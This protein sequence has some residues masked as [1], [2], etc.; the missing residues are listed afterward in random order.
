MLSL[1][2]ALNTLGFQDVGEH[3]PKMKV[4]QKQFYHLSFIHHPDRPGGHNP[5]YQKITEAYKFIGDYIEKHYEPRD[6]TEEE[7]ARRAYKSFNFNDIKENFSS[8]TIKIDNNLSLIWDTILTKH[9]GEPKDRSG[10]GNGKH[11]KHCDYT[12]DN[13]NH[14]DITIGK[15][16]IPKKD[17]QS[18][19]TIQSNVVGNFL[20]AHFVSEHLP[21]LLAE[22][23]ASVPQSA[24]VQS[25]KVAAQQYHTNGKLSETKSK[26][27]LKKK[28]SPGALGLCP[29]P[30]FDIPSPFNVLPATPLLQEDATFKCFLCPNYYS[31]GE[32]DA[33]EKEA[34]NMKCNSCDYTSITKEDMKEH[35]KNTHAPVPNLECDQCPFITTLNRSLKTHIQRKHPDHTTQC[36]VPDLN[37]DQCHFNTTTN[38]SLKTHIQKKHPDQGTHCFNSYSCP[39][40]NYQ[41]SNVISMNQHIKSSHIQKLDVHLS[42]LQQFHCQDCPFTATNVETLSAHVKK[43]H[44]L[45][46]KSKTF[47]CEFCPFSDTHQINLKKHV[48]SKHAKLKCHLCQFT[49]SSEFS[50]TLHKEHNHT[51]IP[52]QMIYP[53]TLCG[54]TFAL[55]GDLESHIH[56]RHTT[57]HDTTAPPPDSSQNHSIALLLEEQIDMATTLK[58]FRESINAQLSAIRDDHEE[59]REDIKKHIEENAAAQSTSLTQF[60]NL[61]S[62]I[63]HQTR[64]I[65]QFITCFASKPVA[66][67]SESGTSSA[68]S[69]SSVPL[70]ATSSPLPPRFPTTSLETPASMENARKTNTAVPPRKSFTPSPSSDPPANARSERLETSKRNK[71]LF[72][73]DSVGNSADIRH[74]EEATNTMIYVEKAFGASY[75]ADAYRP[76]DNFIYVARNAPIK[77]NYSHAVLQGSST[78]ITNLNTSAGDNHLEF[79]KQEVAIASKNMISA[80]RNIILGNSGIKKVLIL[81]RIPRFDTEEADP[82]QLKRELSEYGN[83]VFRDELENSDVK[84]HISIASHTLPTQLQENIYGNPSSSQFD[85]IHLRGHDGRNHYSRSLCNIFQK[86]F[87]ESSRELHNHTI[88]GFQPTSSSTARAAFTASKKSSSLPPKNSS[89]IIDIEPEDIIDGHY[90]Q[91]AVPTYNPFTVL[92][93]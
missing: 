75:K 56:R 34:H 35:M 84:E 20:P 66:S 65:S 42:K 63:D 67:V 25:T 12:D 80:A 30:T 31:Q 48:A 70:T 9:Y 28:K 50:L 21:K 43:K 90:Y 19:M 17:K 79:L 46:I 29:P 76:N 13:S 92:G 33:H 69:S 18:K 16:H 22:V 71:V 32:W 64:S 39:I 86:F 74:L 89:V 41:C 24:V 2:E 8:F 88:P 57:H 58:E 78:D 5:T 3:P 53:C 40:C 81:D 77:R 62:K 6:D 51:N 45:P 4:V 37:C 73:A 10:K 93:N 26:S 91:Y 59:L 36:S 14:G 15:W 54:I 7:V 55:E 61:Q 87:S 47:H 83:K 27:Q 44:A 85:G 38:R 72:I 11:W 49:S 52:Q 23:K 60:E 68:T 82:T 1:I